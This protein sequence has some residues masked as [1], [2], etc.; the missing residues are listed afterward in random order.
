MGPSHFLPEDRQVGCAS[1]LLGHDLG[2]DAPDRGND[3]SVLS[4]TDSSWM[5]NSGVF[6]HLTLTRNLDLV[7]YYF[8]AR[9]SQMNAEKPTSPFCTSHILGIEKEYIYL[10]FQ[11]L[12]LIV[13]SVSICCCRYLDVYNQSY[14]MVMA[15]GR[16]LGVHMDVLASLLIGSV[17]LV[18]VLVSQDAGRCT[19]TYIVIQNNYVCAI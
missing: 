1:C 8:V 3:A 4:D 16:W 5:K 9:W 18:A 6:T 15:S 17:A 12:I 10:R 13:I 2:N 7:S 14:I 19:I 11:G